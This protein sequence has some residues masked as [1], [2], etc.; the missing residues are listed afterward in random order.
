MVVLCVWGCW[1]GGVKKKCLLQ[2]MVVVASLRV[3]RAMK[4][5]GCVGH[6]EMT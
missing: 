2:Y 1:C 6:E 3:T 4:D 5:E